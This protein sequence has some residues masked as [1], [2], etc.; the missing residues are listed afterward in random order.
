VV[1]INKILAS[2]GFAA[3]LGASGAAHADV[4]MWVDDASNNIAKLDLTTKTG[5]FLGNTGAGQTLT[6][7]GFTTNGNLYGVSFDRTYSI[8]TTTGDA[9][10][11]TNNPSNSNLNA[12][13]GYSSTNLLGADS[14]SSHIYSFNTTNNTWT[15]LSGNTGRDSAGDL[16]LANGFY[17]ES[18]VD[19]LGRDTLLKFTVSG[20][21]V[22]NTSTIGEFSLGS[23]HFNDV[24]GLA[25]DGSTMWAVNGTTVYAVNLNNADLTQY[26]DYS[27]SVCTGSGRDKSCLGSVNGAAILP[28]GGVPEPA[29]WGLMIVGTGLVGSQLRR[30]RS[31][32]GAVA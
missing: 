25:F 20:G 2:V 4:V 19:N 23:T 24:F 11:L 5:T 1:N 10:Y 15:T 21:A 6:D 30:R 13:V 26:W 14:D 12:L 27:G 3:V 16:A 32:A 9:T 17:Y 18:A 7:I 28:A 31:V 29:S 8:N 22:T